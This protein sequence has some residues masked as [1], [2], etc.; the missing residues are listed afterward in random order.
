MKKPLTSL[1]VLAA[2]SSAQALPP[3][4]ERPCETIVSVVEAKRLP[5][6]WTTRMAERLDELGFDAEFAC[7]V[8]PAEGQPAI[9]VGE[10]VVTRA[11]VGRLVERCETP[12]ECSWTLERT[13]TLATPTGEITHVQFHGSDF[14]AP[15]T[16]N[17]GGP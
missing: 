16:A 12:S 1:L 9:E 11:T 10:T 2:S 6:D 17:N 14:N 13:E 3:E 5:D 4:N 8:A 15:K 7:A